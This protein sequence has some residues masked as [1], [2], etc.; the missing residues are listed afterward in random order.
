M[1]LGNWPIEVQLGSTNGEGFLCCSK[2]PTRVCTLKQSVNS[3]R[4][5]QWA[6]PLSP[7]CMSSSQPN[8]TRHEA[9][10][11]SILI[12]SNCFEHPPPLP[13]AS[14]LAPRHC[15]SSR[16]PIQRNMHIVSL[17]TSRRRAGCHLAL[18]LVEPN[19]LSEVDH[20]MGG[21]PCQS[22]NTLLRECPHACS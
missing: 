2:G 13:S 11:Q 19:Q 21:P 15:C 3:L 8:P 6:C 5:E 20:P 4:R 14:N 22:S 17:H 9:V 10:P 7:I 1:E 12:P 18:H 16:M